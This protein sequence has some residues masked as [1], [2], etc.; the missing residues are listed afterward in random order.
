M[1]EK[2]AWNSK[3]YEAK[4]I[5]TR[6]KGYMS[7]FSY[8][9]YTFLIDLDELDSMDKEVRFFGRNRF[10]LFSFHDKDHLQWGKD[11]VKENIVAYLNDQG[12]DQKVGKILL[13]T[14]LRVLGYVFNPVSF[15]YIYDELGQ[16]LTAIAEVGNTFGERKPYYFGKVPEEVESTGYDFRLK[17][18]KLFYV[19]PYISLDSKFDFKLNLPS[20]K[21]KI[22]VDSWEDGHKTLGTAYLGEKKQ[23]HSR[24]LFFYFFKYPL[25]T[26]KIIGAIHYRALILYMK[27]IPF[28]RKSDN[29]DK[30]IGVQLGKSH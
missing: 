7:K 20:D 29:P 18:D 5:H 3:L 15:Y 16:P 14:N 2:F 25:V 27:N 10:S 24:N 1:A 26:V 12:L 9:I 23:L 17:T 21:L 13:V 6:T 4:V 22:Q 11:S 8:R 19:S 30:Q 28:L